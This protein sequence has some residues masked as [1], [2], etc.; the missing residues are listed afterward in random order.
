MYHMRNIVNHDSEILLPKCMY[1]LK[2]IY[3]FD[4][5]NNFNELPEEEINIDVRNQIPSG[6][7]ADLEVRQDLLLKKLDILYDRIKTI[8]AFCSVDSVQETKIIKKVPVMEIPEEIVL[9][10]SPDC[11]PWF[12][13]KIIKESAHP[14]NVSWHIHSSVPSERVKK[15]LA[16]VK[17][18]PKF[19]N[20]LKVN[21]RLIFKCV[22]AD[23]ELKLSSLD[24]PIVG[25]VN[26]L[27]YLSLAFPSVIPYDSEDYNV[28]SLLDTCHVLERTTEKN[29]EVLTKK[30][31][32]Q[33]KKWINK[34]EFSILDAATFNILKQ[35]QNSAKY[36]PKDWLAKC[37][38][39][40]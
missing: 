3:S 23:P 6:E 10:Y 27:R 22:S 28:D 8:S 30:I 18:F 17:T 32:S 29:K 24:V 36:A 9:I 34:D 40:F 11:L 26:I 7:M 38:K 19:V 31:F 5:P 20:N 13:K 37:E 16:F 1:N 4:P 2:N 33:N 21:I 39:L 35:W 25:N 15:I 14:V 12:L